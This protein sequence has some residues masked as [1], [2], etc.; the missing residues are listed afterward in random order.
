M[1][2]LKSLKKAAKYSRRLETVSQG[3][4]RGLRD[5]VADMRRTQVQ[6]S[7]TRSE[8]QQSQCRYPELHRT[9]SMLHEFF[10]SLVEPGIYRLDEDVS[11]SSALVDSGT[12]SLDI[13]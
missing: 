9:P 5:E 4:M 12:N 7:E 6:Q 1:Q 8:P 3:M 11:E 10:S 2:E 13:E